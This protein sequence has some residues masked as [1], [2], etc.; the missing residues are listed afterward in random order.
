MSE[1]GRRVQVGWSWCAILASVAMV[2]FAP[3][4]AVAQS[5]AGGAA[6]A[7]VVRDASG[8]VVARARV[9]VTNEEAGWSRDQT[10]TRAGLYAFLRLPP[11]RYTVMV[12]GDG[13]EAF[14]R[15]G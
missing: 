10:T 11:G 1:A 14:T 7:G 8:G 2:A 15:N 5:E 13:F 9:S 4:R 3:G 12:A 6:I